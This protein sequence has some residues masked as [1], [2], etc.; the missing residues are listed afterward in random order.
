MH[1]WFGRIAGAL[2]G[3]VLFASI[4]A[5]PAAAVEGSG[6]DAGAALD[7][8]EDAEARITEEGAPSAEAILGTQ[9]AAVAERLLS[10]KLIVMQEVSKSKTSS[11]R[12]IT[13]LVIFER[14]QDEVYRLLSQTDRQ[15][16]YRPSV[17]QTLTIGF[18]AHGPLDEHRLKILFRSYVYRLEYRLDPE[19]YRISWSLD[20]TFSNDL[21]RVDGSWEL[22]AMDDGR[23]LGR[24][25]TIVEIGPAIPGFLQDW[26]TRS[27]LP[28]TMKEV[29]RWV[30][31]NGEYRR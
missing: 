4:D 13:A 7:G 25:G 9:S 23:T 8:A 21:K 18:R 19:Q 30:D 31:S 11:G 29:R 5:C 1:A 28:E 22:F 17:T 2:L 12:V 26:L 14:P 20:P 27:H 3:A 6:T 24:S 15:I 16:E 10:D